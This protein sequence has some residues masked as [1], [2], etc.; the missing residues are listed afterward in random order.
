MKEFVVRRLNQVLDG[1]A[2][3]EYG[4]LLASD[5]AAISNILCETKPDFSARSSGAE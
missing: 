1:E 4:Y 2:Q 5:R 3:D